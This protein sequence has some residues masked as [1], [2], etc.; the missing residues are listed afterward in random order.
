[1]SDETQEPAGAILAPG[2]KRAFSRG[3]DK[4]EALRER[5]GEVLSDVYCAVPGNSP[6]SREKIPDDT[7]IVEDQVPGKTGPLVGFY[8]LLHELERPVLVLRSDRP[9][10]PTEVLKALLM[11]W[12]EEDDPSGVYVV[13]PAE[14][15][16]FP[17]IVHPRVQGKL[18]H[19][20]QQGD[21]RDVEFFLRSIQAHK[22]TP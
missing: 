13:E 7:P 19:Q 21:P 4:L 9:P 22:V 2:R 12:L 15:I 16:P 17:V 20:I 11:G 3:K 6:I 5:L 1:M 10:P 8:S 18:R 14:N